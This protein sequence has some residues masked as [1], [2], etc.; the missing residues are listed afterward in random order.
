MKM[1]LLVQK[2]KQTKEGKDFSAALLALMEAA[3]CQ[4]QQEQR[5]AELCYWET[6]QGCSKCYMPAPRGHHSKGAT[7]NHTPSD[8]TKSLVLFLTQIPEV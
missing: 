3:L 6:Q 1:R 2:H 7:S 4:P 5:T 8:Q